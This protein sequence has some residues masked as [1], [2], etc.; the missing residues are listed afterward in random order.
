MKLHVDVQNVCED[1]DVPA[2]AMISSWAQAAATAV[3]E[4]DAQLSIRVVGLEE[5]T[6]LNESYRRGDG[7]T[8][9]LSFPFEEGDR[10]DPPLLG[11][12]VI[13][14]DVVLRE[15]LEQGKPATSHYAHM[16]V[17]GVLHLLG[18]DHQREREAQRME[19][20]ER[21][22]MAEMGFDDP[23]SVAQREPAGSQCDE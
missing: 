22:I 7:A 16:V 15:A 18:Y 19:A 23:Y 5:G 8:N 11:D 14:A 1:K 9:V 2:D 13:C 20:L 12:V 10:L 6:D 21:A 3:L 17:H 4:H